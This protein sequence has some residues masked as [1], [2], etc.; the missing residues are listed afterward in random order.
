M[1]IN[2]D[3]LLN[4]KIFVALRDI[5][6]LATTGIEHEENV[7]ILRG[8]ESRHGIWVEA[9]NIN[10]CPVCIDGKK[11][12]ECKAVIFIPWYHIVS[13]VHFPGAKNIEIDLPKAR[14]IG[15]RQK[16]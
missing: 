6:T 16:K 5:K 2:L 15:F 7:F 13:M 3:K 1:E 14:K 4:E 8:H 11:I 12:E 10:A 9:D